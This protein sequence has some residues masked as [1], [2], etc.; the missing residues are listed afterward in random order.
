MEVG[1]RGPCL[2]EAGDLVAAASR[3]AAIAALAGAGELE[4][5]ERW[6]GIMT[7]RRLAVSSSAY[8]G[9][10]EALVAKGSIDCAHDW[11]LRMLNL[12]AGCAATT[13]AISGPRTDERTKALPSHNLCASVVRALLEVRGSETAERCIT[14]L[15]GAGVRLRSSL[16]ARLMVPHARRG[17]FHRTEALLELLEGCGTRPNASYVPHTTHIHYRGM[18]NAVEIVCLWSSLRPNAFI[19]NTLL[20][21]YA[22]ARPPANGRAERAFRNIV[23][24]TEPLDGFVDEAVMR[25]LSRAVGRDGFDKL[26]AEYGLSAVA[27]RA[28]QNRRGGCKGSGG[29]RGTGRG[30]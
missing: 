29:T 7:E 8:T 10:V 21:S 3:G 22:N 25:T 6:L 11:L 5:A 2:T 30:H 14:A 20:L 1:D 17:D 28:L 19:L 24:T 27:E 26:V 9:V 18:D 16:F 23:S 12:T 4:G 13:G 15:V